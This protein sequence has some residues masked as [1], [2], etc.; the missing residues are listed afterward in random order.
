MGLFPKAVGDLDAQ[1][2][3]IFLTREARD[4]AALLVGR[5]RTLVAI[6][7]ASAGCRCVTT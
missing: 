3:E 4:A 5:L 1:I 2:T 6:H 7:V